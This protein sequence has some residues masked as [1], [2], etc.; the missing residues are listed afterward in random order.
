MKNK[1]DGFFVLVLFSLLLFN[2]SCKKSEGAGI[3]VITSGEGYVYYDGIVFKTD[4]SFSCGISNQSEIAG[5]IN[6]W[7]FVF[8]FGNTELLEIS[9][10]NCASYNIIKFENV[11]IKPYSVR[12]IFGETI[13]V[14]E[15]DLFPN[16]DPDNMDI[17]VTITDDNSN[18]VTIHFNAPVSYNEYND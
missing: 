7:K 8:K 14:I 1:F 16:G 12:E 6:A 15:R 9:S 18:Q 3:Y 13:P 4:L 11:P 10:E 17:S 5:T 2:S